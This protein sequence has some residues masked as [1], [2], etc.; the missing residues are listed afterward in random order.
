M[1]SSAVVDLNVLLAPISADNPAGE[2][3]R[4]AGVYDAIQEARRADDEL[5]MGDW[6]R[7]AKAADW[8]A[9]IKL[10]TEA[11]VT[12]SKDLQLA[13][14]LVEALVK[15]HGFPGYGMDFERSEGC[16]KL[17]GMAFIPKSKTVTWSFASAL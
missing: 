14:W 15:R 8:L 4:Y 3:V 5:P 12:K 9:V 10:S 13:V 17:F 6:K 16:R 2:P 7:E 1:A 11:L